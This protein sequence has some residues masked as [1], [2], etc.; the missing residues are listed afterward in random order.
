MKI[1]LVDDTPEI[2]H[3]MAE[4]LR[5]DGH[6]VTTAKDGHDGICKLAQGR[7][8]D[9]IITDLQMPVWDGYKL[10][11]EARKLTKAPIVLHT[12]DSSAKK[13]PDIDFIVSKGNWL[14]LK[15]WIAQKDWPVDRDCDI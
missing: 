9:L 12:G 13:T 10:A 3:S 15:T 14:V 1:L 7:D 6:F 11:K 5:M 4:L 8:V 2:L